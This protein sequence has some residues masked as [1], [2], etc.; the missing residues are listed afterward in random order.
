MADGTDMATMP[1]PT[2]SGEALIHLAIR[3]GG[4]EQAIRGSVTHDKLIT[5]L[6]DQR[7][8]ITVTVRDSEAHIKGML[9]SHAALNATRQQEL[10]QAQAARLNEHHATLDTMITTKV[11]EAVEH[12]MAKREKAEAKA[13]EE[14]DNKAKD[15]TRGFRLVMSGGGAVLGGALMLLGLFILKMTLGWSPFG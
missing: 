11:V 4:M 14:I 15:A 9:E 7:K 2:N 8:E 6:N 5:I 10:Q 3:L 12:V 1:L 13:R